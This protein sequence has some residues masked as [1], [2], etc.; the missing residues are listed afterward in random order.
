[1]SVL[2]LAWAAGFYD[3]EGYAGTQLARSGNRH[4]RLSIGQADRSLLER[5]QRAVY[6][7]G[8]INGPYQRSAPDGTPRKPMHYWR[9]SSCEARRVIDLLTPYLSE[10]KLAQIEAAVGEPS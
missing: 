9:A 8:R 7:L 1:M 10:P 3:G 2:E 5:F 4:L 6:G